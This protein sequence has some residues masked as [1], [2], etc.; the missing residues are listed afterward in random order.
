MAHAFSLGD[1]LEI[2]PTDQVGW[3]KGVVD[4]DSGRGSFIVATEKHGRFSFS[5]SSHPDLRKKQGKR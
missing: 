4:Y 3:V 2:R 5:D 1:E